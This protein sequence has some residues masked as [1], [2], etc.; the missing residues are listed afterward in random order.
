MGRFGLG[1]K[2]ASFSQARRVTVAS[3]CT[4]GSLCV[5]RWDLDHVFNVNEWQLLKKPASSAE[6]IIESFSTANQG[7]IVLWE[8]VDRVVERGTAPQDKPAHDRFLRL[9]NDVQS[10]ISMVFHRFLDGQNPQLKIYMNG[11]SEENRISPWDPFCDSHP[12]T[13]KTPFEMVTHPHGKVAIQGFVLPHKDKLS[14]EDL[15][16]AAGRGGWNQHQGFYIYRNKRMLVGG[17]WLGLGSDKQWTQEEHYRLARILIDIPN[18]QDFDWQIDVKKSTAKPPAWLRDRLKALAEVVR[19]QA[20]EIF[21]HRGAYGPRGQ[22]IQITRA[23]IPRVLNG[24]PVYRI[25]RDHPLVKAAS[26]LAITTEHKKIFDAMLRTIE[27]TVPVSRIWLDVAE[28]P[29]A[30]GRPFETSDEIE[31]RRLVEITYRL[32]R[33]KQG[34]KPDA[35]RH[36]LRMTDGFQDLG[37]IIDEMQE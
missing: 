3:R 32:L 4:G 36:K 25:D 35:A 1:L 19:R 31:K 24:M 34:L 11:E 15:I 33:D 28:Q 18:S 6:A 5:R 20:R 16:I 17:G 26:E 30:H 12:S 27:E 22:A 21:V 10:Y 2:T 37:H 8:L 14:P 13:Y 7:T 29:E 23:W 9:I